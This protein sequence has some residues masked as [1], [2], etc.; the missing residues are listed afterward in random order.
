MLYEVITIYI[1]GLLIISAFVGTVFIYIIP[2]FEHYAIEL[3]KE[4]I[5]NVTQ[6]SITVIESV[7]N[8]FKSGVYSE[9]DAKKLA[10]DSVKA[11]NNF[12]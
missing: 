10:I 9:E 1:A 2:T 4:K 11:R 3:K 5:Q 8:Q 6:S 12:V 7:Y